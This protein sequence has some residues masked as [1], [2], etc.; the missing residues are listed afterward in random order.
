[1]G[2]DD[3]PAN[4]QEQSLTSQK[5]FITKGIT[6][7]YRIP[8]VWGYKPIPL[9]LDMGRPRS[10]GSAHYMTTHDLDHRDGVSRKAPNQTWESSKVL[11]G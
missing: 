7:T 5:T 4:K 3:V 2:T 8:G 1:M 6:N 9:R 10:D 11:V